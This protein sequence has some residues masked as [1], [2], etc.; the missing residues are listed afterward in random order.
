MSI[1]NP[2]VGAG[3][4][5]KRA[6]PLAAAA[7]VLVAT[8]QAAGGAPP[9][10]FDPKDPALLCRGFDGKI[11]RSAALR[12][13]A[14]GFA[15]DVHLA[16]AGKVDVE[17][18]LDLFEKLGLMEGHLMIGKALLDAKMQSDAL[19]HFGH[20]IS[21]IYDYIKPLFL[22]RNYPQFDRELRD[23]EARAKSAPGAPATEAAYADVLAKID[24][25]RRTIPASLINSRGFVI[26]GIALMM[27]ASADDLGES[28][29]KGRIANKVEYHDAMGFAQY[30]D[31]VLTANRALLG[32]AAG[33]IA[34]EL[35]FAL[36][37][38][39]S[40]APPAKPP[41]A[42]A[43]LKTAAERVKELAK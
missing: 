19:P 5:W 26:R 36:S 27:E 37:A 9:A 40:L 24:G 29:E 12:A 34:G 2:G 31:R 7:L 32:D 16:Q 3:L 43:D 21:E 14:A 4:G 18:E 30:A 22:A 6:L 1:A 35:R 39:P 38:F 28:F 13:L 23:L 8:A 42:P 41:H 11:G 10:P 20:P 15:A 25:L 33:K 17:D